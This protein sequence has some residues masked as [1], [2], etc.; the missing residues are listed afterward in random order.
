MLVAGVASCESPESLDGAWSEE[1]ETHISYGRDARYSIVVDVDGPSNRTT[2]GRLAVVV[3]EQ[4]ENCE[5]PM[6]APPET[7]TSLS[8]SCEFPGGPHEDEHALADGTGAVFY[9]SLVEAPPFSVR[10]ELGFDVAEVDA[11][12]TVTWRVCAQ[13]MVYSRRDVD[14]DL[15]VEPI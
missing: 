10:C 12:E 2:S 7:S 9:L 11:V 6:P 5:G 4:F 3:G 1:I 15:V 8:L 14:L 13:V